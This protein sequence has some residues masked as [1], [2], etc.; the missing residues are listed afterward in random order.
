MVI[1]NFDNDDVQNNESFRAAGEE[2]APQVFRAIVMRHWRT[3]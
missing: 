2:P 3:Y 1:F